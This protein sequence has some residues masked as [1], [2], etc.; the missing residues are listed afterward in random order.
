MK[1]SDGERKERSCLR[2]G[3]RFM[4]AWVGNRIC[5]RCSNRVNDESTKTFHV[6]ARR[7][8]A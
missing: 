8:E 2:C 5:S 6:Y 3:K 7:D 1:F 4:S